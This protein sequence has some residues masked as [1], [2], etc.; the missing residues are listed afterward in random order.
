MRI[1]RVLVLGATGLIGVP[2]A[3]QL[4]ADGHHVRVLAREVDRAR[5]QL[6]PELEYVPG[7]VTDSA[8]VDRAVKRRP[9]GPRQP[10]GR[11][12]GP[13]RHR[14]APRDRIRG[15][16]GRSPRT[17]EDQLPHRKS[18]PRGLR[19]Q[20]PRASRQARRRAGD[21][22]IGRSLHVLSPHLLH[23]H[24]PPPHPGAA[25][26]RARPPA[27]GAAPGVRRGLRD[28]GR[29]RLRDARGRQPR[30]LHPRPRAAHPPP[31]TRD[32]PPHRRPRQ[33]TGHDPPAG[34]G[35]D[36]PSLHDRKLEPN[37]QIMRLL[38]KIGERGDP[39]AA[40]DLL[41]APTTTVQTWCHTQAA[42]HPMR[43][44]HP[45]SG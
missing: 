1:E 8:A 18:R 37:L 39:T 19:A 38:A 17:G 44:T 22:S 41:G 3:R 15:G 11:R 35:H 4:L 7:T 27:P 21:P 12:P 33:A 20:D 45:P 43:S 2:V 28:S 10:R 26:R 40:D 36:R 14:R 29:P 34:H 9:R 16:R 5:A 32:L 23:Q 6:G 24:D 13:A 25:D 31:G 42:T 30:L